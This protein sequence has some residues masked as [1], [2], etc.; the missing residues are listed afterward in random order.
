MPGPLWLGVGGTLHRRRARGPLAPRPRRRPA[1]PWLTFVV[2]TLTLSWLT[3]AA[4]GP[5]AAAT[6][7]PLAAALR[8]AC[9]LGWQ[10]VVVTAALAWLGAAAPRPPRPPRRATRVLEAVGVITGCAAAAAV[11]AWLAG[12]PDALPALDSRSALAAA[13]VLLGQAALEEH[14]WRGAALDWAVARWGR[15]RGLLVHAVAWALGYAPLG[16]AAAPA[17][18][19]TVA[20]VATLLA[21]TAIGVG[22]GALRLR[23]GRVVP[24][25]LANAA[26]TIAAGVP[27]VLV[28]G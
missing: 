18:A 22:L 25:A 4:V 2:A 23:G 27:M 19:P 16:I 1:A 8:Y 9:L 11:V 6:T 14:G 17:V 15:P 28:A 20:L 24:A 10:P 26:M 3:I 12:A 7:S 13:A 21:A 5:L